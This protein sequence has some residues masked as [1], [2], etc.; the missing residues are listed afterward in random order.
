MGSLG[1]LC[2]RRKHEQKRAKLQPVESSKKTLGP[3]PG[4]LVIRIP[5]VGAHTLVALSL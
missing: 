5:E 3:Y 1:K 2:R 4:V